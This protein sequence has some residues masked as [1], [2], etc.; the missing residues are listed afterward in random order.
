M[1]N[2]FDEKHVWLIVGG[3]L[4]ILWLFG[5]KIFKAVRI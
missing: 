1:D 3:S 2:D 5:A 4:L